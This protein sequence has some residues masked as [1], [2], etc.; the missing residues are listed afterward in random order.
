MEQG[1]EWRGWQ[2]LLAGT[3]VIALDPLSLPRSLSHSRLQGSQ[4]FS[5]PSQGWSVGGGMEGIGGSYLGAYPTNPQS[6][7]GGRPP[8]SHV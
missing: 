3:G 7:S 5:I 2:E 8:P 6:G 1:W 4:P